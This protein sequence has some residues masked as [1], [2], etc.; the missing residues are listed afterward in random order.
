[1]RF[2]WLHEGKER[3]EL[4][5]IIEEQARTIAELTEIVERLT[6]KRPAVSATL[7]F[8]APSKAT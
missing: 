3:R 1:M 5:R 4:E 7:T 8:V 2:S 6:G